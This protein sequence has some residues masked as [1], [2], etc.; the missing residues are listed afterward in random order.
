MDLAYVFTSE[1]DDNATLLLT[2]DAY[3]E[4]ATFAESRAA[5]ARRA[6][7]ALEEAIAARL[8]AGEDIPHPASKRSIEGLSLRDDG[9][10]RFWMKPGSLLAEKVEL[11]WLLKETGLTRAE[12]ARRLNWK[13]ESVDRLFR[14]DHLTRHRQFDEAKRALG[15]GIDPGLRRAVA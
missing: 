5:I 3:P 6:L 12:L 15:V 1:P 7:G 11:S 10:G 2:C 14:P 4:I 9:T 8:A 13:R